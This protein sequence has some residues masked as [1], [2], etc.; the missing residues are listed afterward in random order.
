MNHI[1]TNSALTAFKTCPRKYQIRY[2][3]GI[4]PVRDSEPL[5]FGRMMHKAVELW[6]RNGRTLNFLDTFF[7]E[8][9]KNCVEEKE[10]LVVNKVS[11]LLVGYHRQYASESFEAVAI[12]QKFEMPLINPDTKNVSNIFKMAGMMDAIYRDKDGEIFIKETKT[13]SDDIEDSSSSYWRQLSIDSQ[14]S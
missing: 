2:E 9:L 3:M 14:I 5:I 1:L 12:E 11:A 4:S 8:Q 10:A 7:N 13:T 6:L